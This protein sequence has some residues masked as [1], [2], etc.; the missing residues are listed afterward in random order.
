MSRRRSL[1]S[2]QAKEPEPGSRAG[3][4]A[5]PFARTRSEVTGDPVIINIQREESGGKV[6]NLPQCNATRDSCGGL[7]KKDLR[8]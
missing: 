5:G 8:I 7:R 4:P 6:C 3:R 1:L 2:C